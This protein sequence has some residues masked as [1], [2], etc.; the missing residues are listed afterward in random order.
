MAD[1]NTSSTQQASDAQHVDNM[2]SMQQS[3]PDAPS[4]ARSDASVQT[5]NV[6]S[7]DGPSQL[8]SNPTGNSTNNNNLGAGSQNSTIIGGSSGNI[9]GGTGL[10]A[11][12]AVL[13]LNALVGSGD[14]VG[15]VLGQGA[16]GNAGGNDVGGNNSGGSADAGAGSAGSSTAGVV[17]AAGARSAVGSGGVGTSATGAGEAATNVT[18]GGGGEGGGNPP[19]TIANTPISP[20]NA[21]IPIDALTAEEPVIAAIEANEE[22]NSSGQPINSAIEAGGLNNRVAGTPSVN[23]TLISADGSAFTAITTPTAS[24]LAYGAYTIDADGTWNYTLNNSNTTVQALNVGGILTDTFTV[25]TVDG[26]VEVVTIKIAGANDNAV[27]AAATTTTF[28][29]FTGNTASTYFND[30][31]YDNLGQRYVI[32]VTSY[33][34]AATK[35]DDAVRSGALASEI[36]T[37][38]AE[39]DIAELI[40][41]ATEYE[42]TNYIPEN[43]NSTLINQGVIS[44]SDVDSVEQFQAEILTSRDGNIGTLVLKADGSY[45]YQITSVLMN[46][47]GR[48]DPLGTTS[49][50]YILESFT[51]LFN[52][53]NNHIDTFTVSSADFTTKDINFILKGDHNILG[54]VMNTPGVIDDQSIAGSLIFAPGTHDIRVIEG[55]NFNPNFGPNIGSLILNEDGSYAYT[56][57]ESAI[58]EFGD[59][60]SGRD[61]FVIT[62]TLGADITIQKMSFNIFQEEHSTLVSAA[63]F[64]LEGRQKIVGTDSAGK[65]IFVDIDDVFAFTSWATIDAGDH[66]ISRFE[67]GDRIDL[68]LLLNDPRDQLSGTININPNAP[69]SQQSILSVLQFGDTGPTQVATVN[70]V[71]SVADLMWQTDWNTRSGIDQTSALNEVSSWTETL[72]LSNVTKVSDNRFNG[73][74]GWWLEITSDTD[75]TEG[76]GQITFDGKDGQVTIHSFDGSHDISN[77]DKIIWSA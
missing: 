54:N 58:A 21:I 62:S 31:Y 38:E 16:T 2:T 57:S 6:G 24:A 50:T 55:S 23:N 9:G 45:T 19:P 42:I 8:N 22:S 59:F 15:G 53:S 68:S 65:D 37:L 30:A 51:T 39:R 25:S 4:G 70:G 18:T 73:A 27:I 36:S 77:I 46:V 3:T 44:V 63:D 60:I 41:L 14:G 76:T 52:A 69:S 1:A 33:N 5:N 43:G 34:N 32:E 7:Q 17:A 64:S 28:G 12:D 67:L 47:D 11:G 29:S 48:Y 26:A 66:S 71:W 61:T 49:E 75:I 40:K 56:L 72:D 35:Y 74:G 10:G 13:A 20:S